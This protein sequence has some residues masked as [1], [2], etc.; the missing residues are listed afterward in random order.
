MK[1][2]YIRDEIAV[3]VEDYQKRLGLKNFSDA[4]NSLLYVN[5]NTQ[6]PTNQPTNN[7]PPKAGAIDDLD[8]LF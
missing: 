2:A 1:R 5:S 6:Q 3:M 8:G 4:V 7:Q